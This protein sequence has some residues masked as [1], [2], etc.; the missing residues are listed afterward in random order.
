M[1]IPDPS[2]GEAGIANANRHRHKKLQ[3]KAV[4]FNQKTRSGKA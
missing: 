3:E 2:I 4:L 1:H